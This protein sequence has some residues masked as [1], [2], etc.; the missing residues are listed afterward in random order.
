[1]ENN[2]YGINFKISFGKVVSYTKIHLFVGYE[3]FIT[4]YAMEKETREKTKLKP[5]KN[6]KTL[7]SPLVPV[8]HHNRC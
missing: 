5:N 6:R 7:K 8:V 3:I 2:T 4:N 1:M